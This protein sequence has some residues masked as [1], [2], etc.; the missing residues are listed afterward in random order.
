MSGRLLHR[1]RTIETSEET[2]WISF[3]DLMTALL[4]VFMLAA[5]ALVFSLTQEQDALADVRAE[6]EAAQARGD[7][8]DTMLTSLG[9]SERIRSEMVLEIQQALHAQGIEVDVDPATSVIR[10]PVDLLGFESGSSD[11]QPEHRTNALLIGQVI[12]D[13]LLTDTRYTQLDTVFVEGHTDDIPME[14]LH[15]GNWGLSAN[16]AISLWRLW[17]DELSA[18]LGGLTGPTGERLF[19]VSGYAE[20]R[21]VSATQST[22]AERAANRRI[23]IRF[24]EHKLSEEDIS[25]LRGAADEAASP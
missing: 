5:V 16:R 19:S 18:D 22:D 2:V 8:F 20:T 17:E 23:D 1:R 11:I 4:A 12:A 21:P 7:R 3:S 9:T 14:G 6:A 15:G 10:V 24:T 13:V 25:A